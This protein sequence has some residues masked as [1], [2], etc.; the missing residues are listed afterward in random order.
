MARYDFGVEKRIYLNSLS[1]EEVDSAVAE[2]VNQAD[3]INSAL[4]GGH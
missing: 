4:P 1:E 2:L 3:N